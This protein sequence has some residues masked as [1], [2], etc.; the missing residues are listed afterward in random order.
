MRSILSG[1]WVLA[2]SFAAFGA[3]ERPL[4]VSVA[5][6]D[7]SNESLAR[8]AGQVVLIVNVASKCDLAR[9]YE[10]LETLYERYRERGFVVLGFPSNDFAGEEPGSNQEIADFCRAN[11]GVQFPMY[12]KLHVSGPEQHPLYRR[13]TG[14]RVP[15]GGPIEGSF[16]KFLVARDGRVVDRLAPRVEPLSDGLVHKIEILLA[17]SPDR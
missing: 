15:L 10:G 13:L 6:L 7:G 3:S 12:G 9:Q 2:L 16:E 5:R 11:W 1:L 14:L 17:E 8:Y 4:E